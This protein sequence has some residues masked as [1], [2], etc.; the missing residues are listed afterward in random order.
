MLIAPKPRYVAEEV[1]VLPVM[2]LPG[3]PKMTIP[4]SVLPVICKTYEP[5]DYTGEIKG[6]HPA[7][8]RVTLHQR[9]S[10]I[11]RDAIR[12]QAIAG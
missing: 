2:V 9:I 7:T 8:N 4:P 12:P 3:E 11:K 6:G 10:A 5:L 1:M